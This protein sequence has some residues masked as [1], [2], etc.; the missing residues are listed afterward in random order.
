MTNPDRFYAHGKLLITGEYLVLDGAKA[1]ALPC[2]F[3]QWL[4][5]SVGDDQNL[6]S[7]NSLDV[8]GN[9]WFSASFDQQLN[10]IVTTDEIL[11]EKLKSVLEYVVRALPENRSFLMG[12]LVESNLEFERD[13]GLGTSSTLIHLIGQ[14]TGMDPFELVFNTFGGSGYD[15]ACA[16]ASGPIMYGIGSPPQVKRVSFDPEWKENLFFIHLGKKQLSDVEVA[17]YSD[18]EFDRPLIVSQVNDLTENVLNANSVGQFVEALESHEQLLSKTLGYDTIKSQWFPNINGT[19]KSLGAWGGDF[20]LFVGE[21]SE[22]EKI[23]D[24]GFSTIL[25][26]E[27][28]VFTTDMESSI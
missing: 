18:L 5:V 15:V 3:G 13:W 1:L 21:K 20:V 8:H 26:W 17:K 2:K 12:T 25:K 11:A 16:D 4:E 28:M 22:I 10:I 7:W 14:W 9:S 6:F 19:I 24:L 27:D 23:K